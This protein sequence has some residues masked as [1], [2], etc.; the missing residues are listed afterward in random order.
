DEVMK[1]IRDPD[2]PRHEQTAT[3]CE[4]LAGYLTN[5][6]V[7]P[8][9]AAARLR[10]V[11]MKELLRVGLLHHLSR[12]DAVSERIFAAAQRALTTCLHDDDR[13]VRIETLRA[14]SV[15]LRNVRV[16]TKQWRGVTDALFPKGLGSLTWALDPVVTRLARFPLRKTGSAL[17]SSA[18][19]RTSVLTQVFRLFPRRTLALCDYMT[20][21]SR[22]DDIVRICDDLLRRP[23]PP[24]DDEPRAVAAQFELYLLRV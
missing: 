2:W 13:I 10:V 21:A 7:R 24:D 19:Y 17:M 16:M 20:R 14:L 1:A 3:A 23:G 15:M 22:S 5:V 18:W 4:I 11:V 6:L 12:Q 8:T 9:A